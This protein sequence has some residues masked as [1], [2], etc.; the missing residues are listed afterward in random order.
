MKS[1]PA[2]VALI[3]QNALIE[4]LIVWGACSCLIGKRPINDFLSNQISH[5]IFVFE[6]SN[7][8]FAYYFPG[9]VDIYLPSA[10]LSLSFLIHE[11]SSLCILIKLSSEITPDILPCSSDKRFPFATLS[12]SRSFCPLCLSIRV[13]SALWYPCILWQTRAL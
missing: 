3:P 9:D 11:F 7:H 2:E 1:M 6:Y 10:T 8:P 13:F 5:Y 4:R 12:H